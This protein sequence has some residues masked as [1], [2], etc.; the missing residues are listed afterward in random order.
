MAIA[1]YDTQQG[2]TMTLTTDAITLRLTNIAAVRRVFIAIRSTYLS[3]TL[4]HTYISGELADFP[5][6]PVTYQ[7][8]P[9][10]ANPTGGLA[11]TFTITMPV[12]P[13]GSVAESITGT[14]FVLE[15]DDTASASS[16]SEG[17][18]MKSFM[19][20]PDGLTGPTRT[21]GS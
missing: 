19:F 4:K 6:F 16:D 13:G 20:K 12:A 3:T 14:G 8:S 1:A 18:Q 15:G 2:A 11:Q 7:N 10:L 21:V 17:L 5:A 9:G